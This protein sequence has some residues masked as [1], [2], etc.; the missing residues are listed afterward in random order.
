MYVKRFGPSHLTLKILKTDRHSYDGCRLVV[1]GEHIECFDMT[2]RRPCWCS[3][4]KKRRPYWCTKSLLWKLNSIFMKKST[5]VLVKDSLSTG[6]HC[7]R[8]L[9]F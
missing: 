7:E 6:I 2:S 3:K 4:T 9:L 5:F 8:L 1:K